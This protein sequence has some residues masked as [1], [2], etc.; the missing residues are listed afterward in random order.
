MV[1]PYSEVL[2]TDA[3]KT[4]LRRPTYSTEGIMQE[5]HVAFVQKI[6]ELSVS[7][8]QSFQIVSI[9]MSGVI[10]SWSVVEMPTVDMAGSEIDLGLRVGGR[11]KLTKGSSINILNTFNVRSA[12]GFGFAIDPSDHQK[13][14]YSGAGKICHGSRFGG[15]SVTP[16]FYEP[17]FES[18][19]TSFS[20]SYSDNYRYFLVG[21]AC[22]S[23]CLFDK[24]Y[25]SPVTSWM[26]VSE[27]LIKI[28]WDP[29]GKP[30]FYTID[31]EQAFSIWDLSQNASG[32]MLKFKISNEK[33]ECLDWVMPESSK[34]SPLVCGGRGSDIY[35]YSLK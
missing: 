5:G 27:P 10:I 20:F 33:W 34:L 17:G 28:Q 16:K 9:D 18:T 1:F 30:G 15:V 7:K 11:I 19:A 35:I 32:P 2:K 6:V 4:T 25:L 24:E 23:I 3:S 21:F 31:S 8:G 22:G 14:L 13:F 12:Q 29:V 26:H